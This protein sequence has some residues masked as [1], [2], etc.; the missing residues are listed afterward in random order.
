[1]ESFQ[2]HFTEKKKLTKAEKKAAL[3]LNQLNE[4]ISKQSP[5][6]IRKT[7]FD[8]QIDDGTKIKQF[9]IRFK[10]ANKLDAD[11]IVLMLCKKLKA[12][13]VFIFDKDTKHNKF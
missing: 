9:F 13:I 10:D 11:D 3:K 8:I 1:M 5:I 12:E 7:G 6:F 2:T 4:A